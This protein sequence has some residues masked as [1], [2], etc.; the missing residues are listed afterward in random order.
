MGSISVITEND[1]CIF[2]ETGYVNK[3]IINEIV[4]KVVCRQQLNV[5]E[6]AI[7]IEKSM[8]I[9]KILLKKK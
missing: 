1:W 9:E 5:R 4:D 7:R 6:Q 2:V 8:E 3:L